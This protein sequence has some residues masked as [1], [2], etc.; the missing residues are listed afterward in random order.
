MSRY[1]F[2]GHADSK[3]QHGPTLQKLADRA[4]FSNTKRQTLENLFETIAPLALYSN[5][6]EAA[7]YPMMLAGT[8]KNVILNKMKTAGATERQI[9]DALKL[10]FDGKGYNHFTD[11]A[12]KLPKQGIDRVKPLWAISN[13]PKSQSIGVDFNT[14]LPDNIG[15]SVIRDPTWLPINRAKKININANLDDITRANSLGH[16]LQHVLDMNVYNRSFGTNPSEITEKQR[17]LA[18]KQHQKNYPGQSLSNED[19]YYHNIGEMRGRLNGLLQTEPEKY[20]G[21]SSIF[22]EYKHNP[23]LYWE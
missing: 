5:E 15:G 21:L 13:I 8:R 4:E 12:L 3:G 9:F 18:T 7:L 17:F 6:A 23:D 10:V 1:L 2:Q 20:Q 22:G 16:E 11:D 19:L 14:R